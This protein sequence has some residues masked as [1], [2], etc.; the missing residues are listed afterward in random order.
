M[1]I[2]LSIKKMLM[3]CILLITSKVPTTENEPLKPDHSVH[4]GGRKGPDMA[5]APEE[6]ANSDSSKGSHPH[7]L[8]YLITIFSP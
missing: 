6:Q 7:I 4:P 1:Q 3:H 2:N 8:I 5:A